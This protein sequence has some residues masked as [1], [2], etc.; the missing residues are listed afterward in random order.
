M[1]FRQ[2]GSENKIRRISAVML[3][4]LL[5]AA[6]AASLP[7]FGAGAGLSGDTDMVHAYGETAQPEITAKGAIEAVLPL[8][9]FSNRRLQS[10]VTRSVFS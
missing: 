10:M 1:R 8:R 5:I 2:A 9:R 3:A 7:F 6:L 4:L